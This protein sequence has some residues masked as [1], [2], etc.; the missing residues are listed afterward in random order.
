M[1]HSPIAQSPAPR[2]GSI[3]MPMTFP[4]A[5]AA[6]IDAKRITRLEW[7]DPDTYGMLRDGRLMLFRSDMGK[8]WHHWIISEGD[9]LGDD[10]VIKE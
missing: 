9:L 7:D 1:N 10:W 2:V 5:M 4:V 3:E 8:R 6:I